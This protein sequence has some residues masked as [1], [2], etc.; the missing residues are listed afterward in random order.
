MTN[1]KEYRVWASMLQRCRNKRNVRYANYGG[2]GIT[3]CKRWESF[4][5]FYK[6][7]GPRPN[8]DLSL[9]RIN[10]DGNYEKNNCRWATRTE[11]QRNRRKPIKIIINGKA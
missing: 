9:D 6:D 8:K 7:M 3:I 5:N 11:Q 10:N 2:R 4:I 1:S